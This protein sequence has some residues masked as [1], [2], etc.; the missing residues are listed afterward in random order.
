MEATMEQY[1]DF[2]QKTIPREI[3]NKLLVQ[4]IPYE[5]GKFLQ[6]INLSGDDNTFM[7]G[8][9]GQKN[10]HLFNSFEKEL[11]SFQIG[12]GGYSK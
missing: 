10:A 4:V 8:V 1:I 11:P 12:S 7:R 6:I 3:L 9:D 5:G 2:S